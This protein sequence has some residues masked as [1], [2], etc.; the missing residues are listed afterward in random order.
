MNDSRPDATVTQLPAPVATPAAVENVP[1]DFAKT[2]LE[3]TYRWG[4]IMAASGFFADA[5]QAAQAAVKIQAGHELGLQ[6]AA[7]M[8]GIFVF[9]GKI[10]LAAALMTAKVNESPNYEYEVVTKTPELVVLKWFGRSKRTGQWRELGDSSF[11]AAD[12]T[13]AGL[14]GKD[15][16]KKYPTAMKFARAV[17]AG[18]RMYCPELFNGAAY[19]PEEVK[20]TLIVDVDGNV[21]VDTAPPEATRSEV[22]VTPITPITR[23]APTPGKPAT[24]DE[25]MAQIRKLHGI[26]KSSVSGAQMKT[27]LAD[28]TRILGRN[29]KDVRAESDEVLQA[30]VHRKAGKTAGEIAAATGPAATTIAPSDDDIVDQPTSADKMTQ[31]T[32]AMLFG[33]LASIGVKT[34]ELRLAFANFYHVAVA[35]YTELSEAEAETL[36][37]HAKLLADN[38]IKDW[39]WAWASGTDLPAEQNADR[40]AMFCNACG[41]QIAPADLA[42][43][44]D[45]DCEFALPADDDADLV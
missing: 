32:K 39:T 4:K 20:E 30:Y 17:S 18:C 19:V 9:D 11:S 12:V 24:R 14:A 22:N 2:H 23:T 31:R 3:N 13:T 28:M 15:N 35:S 25:I 10:S 36:I 38:G 8:R 26:A 33:V 40:S 37:E 27:I 34:K 1:A 43:A 42:Q 41:V 29:V 45:P 5:K 21:I 16:H 44:H 6:P 7:S